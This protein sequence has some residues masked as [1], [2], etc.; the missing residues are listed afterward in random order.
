MVELNHWADVSAAEYKAHLAG[1]RRQ[2]RE[3]AAKGAPPAA[4]LQLCCSCS[5]RGAAAPS[6]E[7]AERGFV[8]RLVPGCIGYIALVPSHFWHQPARLVSCYALK[9]ELLPTS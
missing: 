7:Q 8:M 6:L 2:R 3:W 4:V 1:N 9:G 5:R